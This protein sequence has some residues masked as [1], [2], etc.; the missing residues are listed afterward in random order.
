MSAAPDLAENGQEIGRPLYWIGSRVC[1]WF[2]GEL[3][4][5]FSANQG[6]AHLFAKLQFESLIDF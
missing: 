1:Y 3:T 5:P 6:V 4:S 2:T